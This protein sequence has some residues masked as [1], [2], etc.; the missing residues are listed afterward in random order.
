MTISNKYAAIAVLL[1]E[2]IVDEMTK[3]RQIT[4]SGE[5]PVGVSASNKMDGLGVVSTETR[6]AVQREKCMNLRTT[7]DTIEAIG[8]GYI[9]CNDDDN[10]KP[11]TGPAPLFDALFGDLLKDFFDS[12]GAATVGQKTPPPAENKAERAAYEAA[13]RASQEKV[14]K[15][16]KF[17]GLKNG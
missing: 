5:G 2:V 13:A 1:S 17:E 14:A 15:N 7:R 9:G 12:K 8:A 4:A 16:M 10:K 3:L 11:E 6:I